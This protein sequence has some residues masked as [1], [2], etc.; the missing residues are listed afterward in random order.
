MA[1]RATITSANSVFML[2][3]GGIAPIPQ[4]IQGF[5]SDA[6][7]AFEDINNKEIVMGVDGKMSAGYV[8]VPKPM[9]VTIMPNSS[10]TSLFDLW[11][12]SEETAREVFSADATL[13]YPAI[14]KKFTLTYG[15]LSRTKV[16]PTVGKTLQPVEYEITWESATASLI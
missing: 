16:A 7:W 8:F 1:N 4:Q 5:A 6:A 11:Y 12:S 3:I 13:V 10:S 2:A 14:G 15:V 9:K